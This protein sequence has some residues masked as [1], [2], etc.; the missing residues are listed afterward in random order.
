MLCQPLLTRSRQSL[1]ARRIQIPRLLPTLPYCTTTALIRPIAHS[2]KHCCVDFAYGRHL[3]PKRTIQKRFVSVRPLYAEPD[4]QLAGSVIPRHDKVSQL[5]DLAADMARTLYAAESPILNRWAHRIDSIVA[6]RQPSRRTGILYMDGME[7]QARLITTT[8]MKILHKENDAGEMDYLDSSVVEFDMEMFADWLFSCK[9]VVLVA[10]RIGVLQ[11]L[12]HLPAFRLAIT[13]HPR[14]HLVVDGMDANSATF[15]VFADLLRESLVIAGVS[16]L[17]PVKLL[18]WVISLAAIR[19]SPNTTASQARAAL[20]SAYGGMYNTESDRIDILACSLGAAISSAS[21]GGTCVFAP[22]QLNNAMSTQQSKAAKQTLHLASEFVDAADSTDSGHLSSPSRRIQSEFEDGDLKTVD[23]SIGVIKQRI[24]RWFASGEIWL[25]ALMRVYEV[26][27]NLIDNAILDRMFED[28]DLGMVHAT[29]RL[30]ESISRIT[31]E[32]AK[33]IEALGSAEHAGTGIV[34]AAADSGA[35]AF[36]SASAALRALAAQKASI[37]TFALARHVWAARKQLL[38]EGIQDSIPRYIHWSLAQ[39]WSIHA[40]ALACSATSVLYFGIPLHYATTGGL[41][42]G[43][44]AFVWLGHRWNQ[45]RLGLFETMDRQGANLRAELAEAHR[46]ALQT[47][48][49]LPIASCVK[50]ITVLRHS[51]LRNI[52]QDKSGQCSDETISTWKSRLASALS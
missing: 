40:A 43:V 49:D 24:R 42:L 48:L 16:T 13:L 15:G 33:E 17:P 41:G 21:T 51:P 23:T 6:Q 20:E 31:S 5:R 4:D 3:Q 1:V 39:F 22:T 27:D 26:S 11:A 37:E 2:D 30:N 32:L 50:D 36:E 45:L 14:V 34:G 10:D 18:H 52:Y 46:A 38:Q 12:I 28:A 35:P 25:T 44:L 29:G 7:A 8:A 9:S 19:D 47:R